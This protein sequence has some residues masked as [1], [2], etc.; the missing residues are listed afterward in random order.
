MSSDDYC[1]G[2]YKCDCVTT[3]TIN[4]NNTTFSFFD[5]QEFPNTVLS[6]TGDIYV[7]SLMLPAGKYL[8]YTSFIAS[9]SGG[10]GSS[11]TTNLTVNPGLISDDIDMKFHDNDRTYQ[12]SRYLPF[13]VASD[14]NI[15]FILSKTVVS[16][17][18]TFEKIQSMV[19]RR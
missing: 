1:C 7:Y 10:G 2:E 13:T 9:R 15:D 8:I 3:T 16:S 6:G 4:L 5:F 19:Y 17:M 11:S 18:F 12:F 14:A